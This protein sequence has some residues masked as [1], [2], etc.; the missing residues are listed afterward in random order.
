MIPSYVMIWARPE[1]LRIVISWHE[2]SDSQWK[3]KD[4]QMEKGKA[5]LLIY[6]KIALAKKWETG[7]K[8][9]IQIYWL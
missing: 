3:K 1:T 9:S 8:K 7:W 4:K 2:E 6:V 5:D